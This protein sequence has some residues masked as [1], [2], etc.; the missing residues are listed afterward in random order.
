VREAAARARWD[1]RW[2]HAQEL[3]EARS[4]AMAR[5][6]A[7]SDLYAQTLQEAVAASEAVW[8]ALP[9]LPAHRPATYGR[10]LYARANLYLY[11]ATDGKCGSAGLSPHAARQRPGLLDLDDGAR[12]ILLLP[13]TAAQADEAIARA[14]RPIHPGGEDPARLPGA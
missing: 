7:A 14:A 4:E 9:V 13:L 8:A 2:N 12:E 5:L 1:A 10:D 6:Q 11:G 3:M